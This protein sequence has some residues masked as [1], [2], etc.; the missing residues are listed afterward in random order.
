MVPNA[1]VV[2]DTGG[3]SEIVK[4]VNGLKAYTNNV[5]SLADNIIWSLQHP[6]HT[7]QMKSNALSDI[8]K[9]YNWDMIANK[10]QE[11]Y[12][13]VLDEFYK[14]PWLKTVYREA[15]YNYQRDDFEEI[16]RYRNIQ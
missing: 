11:V 8:E 2:S 9:L 10:T 5:I 13:Q 12:Q 6:D 3:M 1:V 14:S 4:W 16:N 7:A 15:A